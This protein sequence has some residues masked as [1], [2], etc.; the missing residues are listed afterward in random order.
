MEK[1]HLPFY[2]KTVIDE[3]GKEKQVPYCVYCDV[4]MVKGSWP[5]RKRGVLYM[6]YGLI[7]PEC[8]NRYEERYEYIGNPDQ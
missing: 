4:P 7:C 8:G 2:M 6:C 5:E 3:E 1:K